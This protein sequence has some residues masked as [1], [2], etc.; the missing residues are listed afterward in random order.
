M[1]I[2]SAT[3]ITSIKSWRDEKY[4]SVSSSSQFFMNRPITF[5]PCCFNNSAATEEST[6]PDKPT[7]TVF[8]DIGP[9]PFLPVFQRQDHRRLSIIDEPAIDHEASRLAILF[10]LNHRR[11][12]HRHDAGKITAL[13]LQ[14]AVPTQIAAPVE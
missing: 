6:P 11:P 8:L 5:Q 10:F 2:R 4:S 7:T 3:L 9:S 12:M 13:R 1:P 14:Q